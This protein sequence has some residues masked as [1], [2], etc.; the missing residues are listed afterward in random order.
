MIKNFLKNKISLYSIISLVILIT[1]SIFFIYNKNEISNKDNTQ[2]ESPI[3][4]INNY[5]EKGVEYKENVHYKKL[6]N[7]IPSMNNEIIEY[8][9]YKCSHCYNFDKTLKRNY[10]KL[11][12]NN[13]T[14]RFEHA[15][16]SKNWVS[17]AQLF[18]AFRNLNL[19]KKSLPLMME[20]F[21]ENN[22]KNIKFEDILKELE[23]TEYQLKESIISEKVINDLK[24]SHKY[25]MQAGIT[26]TPSLII[27]GKYLLIN[28]AFKSQDEML[29]AAIK[30]SEYDNENK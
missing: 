8:F 10:R 18:Y 25:A 9:W 1:I 5:V 14:I 16:I 17:D 3:I 7:P 22:N 24:E 26:G 13:I 19:E 2:I 4:D 15:A 20:F 6:L 30:I 11:I 29:E 21:H 12:D 28:S 23:I 27:E